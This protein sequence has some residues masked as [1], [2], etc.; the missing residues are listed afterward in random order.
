MAVL[1]MESPNELIPWPNR[2]IRK[3]WLSRSR[4][5]S[6][7]IADAAGA[8][9]TGASSGPTGPG[10]T[11]P[12]SGRSS[13]VVTREGTNRSMGPTGI[14]PGSMRAACYS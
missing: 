14:P 1:V 9:W 2:T 4:G 11:T 12:V 6:A 13:R 8:R 3:S 5:A 10:M 7:A